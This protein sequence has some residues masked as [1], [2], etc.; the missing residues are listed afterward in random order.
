MIPWKMNSHVAELLLVLQV[1]I[2][3]F[4]GKSKQEHGKGFFF[5][6]SLEL[7]R[8]L[9]ILTYI[10]LSYIFRKKKYS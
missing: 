6:F 8:K 4:L 10:S 2:F 9:F 3:C 1:I 5:F 7:K